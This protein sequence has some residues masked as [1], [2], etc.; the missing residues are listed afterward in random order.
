MVGFGWC[1]VCDGG[2]VMVCLCMFGELVV[3]NVLL[4]VLGGLLLLVGLVLLVFIE[5]GLFVYC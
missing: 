2:G 1:V 3:G 5:N 4:K